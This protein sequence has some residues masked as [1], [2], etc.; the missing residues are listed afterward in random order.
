MQ[1]NDQ[2]KK[3]FDREQ[4]R[5]DLN[6]L[7][8]HLEHRSWTF[9]A[10]N[11]R[12]FLILQ[13]EEADLFALATKLGMLGV[14]SYI[15]AQRAAMDDL[16][17]PQIGEEVRRNDANWREVVEALRKQVEEVK[18]KYMTPVDLFKEELDKHDWW[19]DSSDSLSVYKAGEASLKKLLQKAKQGGYDFQCAIVD[20]WNVT[21]KVNTCWRELEAKLARM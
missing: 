3:P 19:T 12:D 13:E 18:Q 14:K 15:D 21:Y 6:S 16:I 9:Q 1:N 17:R 2:T 20:K 5:K 8:L 4:F 10:D 7:R 11:Y